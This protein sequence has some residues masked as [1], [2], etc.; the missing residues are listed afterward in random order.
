M[1]MVRTLVAGTSTISAYRKVGTSWELL[2]TSDPYTAD[3]VAANLTVFAN[4]FPFPN[5]TVKVAYDNFRVN[6]GAI[7]CPTS[8]ANNPDWQATH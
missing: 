8:W 5:T 6:S 3:E 2:R 1:R 7:S 4:T